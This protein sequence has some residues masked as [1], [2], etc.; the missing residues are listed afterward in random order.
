MGP[1]INP[2]KLQEASLH[3]MSFK[4]EKEKIIENEVEVNYSS[5]SELQMHA[6]NLFK[7]TKQLKNMPI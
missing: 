7:L 6:I 5:L 3:Y 2:L 1:Y 4:S